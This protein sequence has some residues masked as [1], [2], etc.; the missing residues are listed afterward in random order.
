MRGFI[1]INTISIISLMALLI[2][3]LQNNLQ[4]DTRNAIHLSIFYNN[5]HDL[6]SSALE[7]IHNTDLNKTL[8]KCIL[9]NTQEVVS[10]NNIIFEG[11]KAMKDDIYYTVS[12]L[13]EFVCIRTMLDGNNF[14][15]HH[16]ILNIAHKN[17]PSKILQ[18]RYSL[19][20]KKGLCE[21]LVYR[22]ISPGVTSWN[23]RTVF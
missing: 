22:Y 21:N 18:I 1:L 3:T 2:L 17:L 12:D 15:T 16:Y 8:D 4:L 20:S 7:I 23:L 11:C 19:I 13:G 9:K 6:E 14:A 10:Y 5:L